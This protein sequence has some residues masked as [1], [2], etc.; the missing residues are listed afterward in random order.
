MQVE[1]KKLGESGEKCGQCDR[2]MTENRQYIKPIIE[3]IVLVGRQ[4]IALRGHRDDGQIFSSFISTD[5]SSKT[6][7]ITNQ[8]NSF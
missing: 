1:K 4:N 7:S 6:K 5:L 2:N 3:S 8:G